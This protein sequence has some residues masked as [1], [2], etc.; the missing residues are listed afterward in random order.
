MEGNSSGF[1]STSNNSLSISLSAYIDTGYG[2]VLD[3]TCDERS[4]PDE[5]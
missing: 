5:E 2:E 3:K 1:N 4:S